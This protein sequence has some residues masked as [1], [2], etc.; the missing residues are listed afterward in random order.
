[1]SAFFPSSVATQLQLLTAKNNTMVILAADCDLDDDILTVDDA[2]SLP[3]SG[4]MTFVDT[5]EVIYYAAKTSNTLT[6]VTRG[7]DGTAPA[8]HLAG[9]DLEQRWNADYHNRLTLELVA[10]QQFISDVIGRTSTQ[11]LAPAGTGGAPG[12]SFASNPDT[13]MMNQFPNELDFVLNGTLV[14]GMTSAQFIAHYRISTQTGGSAAN[15]GFYFDTDAAQNSGLY[16]IGDGNIAL[17]ADGTK[18]IDLKGT[19]VGIGGAPD[20]KAILALTSTTLG[21]L[22][23]VMTTTQRDAIASPTNGLVIYNSTT[24]A[25]NVYRSSAWKALLV[26]GLADIVN[27]DISASAAI[28]YSKLSLGTSIV[29]ADINGSAAIAYSKLNL[30]TSIVNA[31]INASAAIAVSKLAAVTASKALASDASGFVSASTVTTTELQGLHSLTASRAVVTDGSGILGVSSVTSTELGYVSGVTSAIQTQLNALALAAADGE[32]MK[33]KIIN[34]EMRVDQAN[35][36]SA[37]TVNSGSVTYTLDMWHAVGTASAGVFTV[38]RLKASPPL[39]YLSY[40]RIAVTTNSASPAAGAIYYFAQKLEVNNIRDLYTDVVNDVG[41]KA[42]VLSF[43]VR[44]SL[45]G[46][47]SGYLYNA[48]GGANYFYIF[49]YAISSANTWESKS[50]TISAGSGVGALAY[51][52]L[53]L[54]TGSGAMLAFDLGSGSNFEDTVGWHN[55]SGSY[56]TSASVRVISTNSATWDITAVQLELG[57]TA[58]ALEART[59]ATEFALCQRYYEKTYAPDTAPATNTGTNAQSHSTSQVGTTAMEGG[60]VNFNVQKRVAP[61]VTLYTVPGTSGKQAWFTTAGAS[62][63]RSTSAG[64][65]STIGFDL[66]QSVAVE[67]MA[68]GHWVA[69]ARM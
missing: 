20:T 4:Y 31:D 33:N 14:L 23:P 36:G 50:V 5:D 19:G 52:T 47:F 18:M 64:L 7:S 45:T 27:A 12:V 60:Y 34:A 9:V 32:T 42:L 21:F 17:S 67:Y 6:G 39:G 29:N 41:F 68:Y 15:P 57:S 59:W 3:D 28:A 53:A 61:T 44:S 65:L 13:G 2:S 37:V 11:V 51:D 43:K 38:Q 25:L 54:A 24:S 26:P 30:A 58:T 8:T 10:T 48:S 40:A 1:M 62:T 55:S 66:S 49:T 46:T 56:R 69:D 63:E 35:T 16:L 22:P